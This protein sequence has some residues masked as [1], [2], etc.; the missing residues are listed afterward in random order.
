MSQGRNQNEASQSAIDWQLFFAA[1]NV[2]II[3]YDPIN[4]QVIIKRGADYSGLSATTSHDIYIYDMRTGSWT[5]S[6]NGLANDIDVTN[7]VVNGS[8]ELVCKA[9][10]DTT[11]TIYKWRPDPQSTSTFQWKSKAYDFGHPALKKKLYKVI[12]HSKEGDNMDVKVYYDNSGSAAQAFDKPLNAGSSLVRN[13]LTI[14]TPTAFS[15]LALEIASDGASASD[16]EVND[17][18]LVYRILRPH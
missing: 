8:S 12:I 15:Y 1:N 17:I 11:A 2:P 4:D 6:M 10:N 14:T 16:F 5:K 3:G 13:E 7:F 18:A 9:S